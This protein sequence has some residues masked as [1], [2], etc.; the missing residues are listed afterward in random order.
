MYMFSSDKYNSGYPQKVVER[1]ICIRVGNLLF[2][3][4]TSCG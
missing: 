1:R 2:W 4:S 3:L